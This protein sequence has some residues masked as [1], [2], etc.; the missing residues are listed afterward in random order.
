MTRG[1]EESTPIFMTRTFV[2]VLDRDVEQIPVRVVAELD[3]NQ[4]GETEVT[5]GS[6]V[7]LTDAARAQGEL[8]NA[9]HECLRCEA[10][11]RASL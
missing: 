3:K 7:R 1:P 10:M 11:E 8:I 9:E 6:V 5:I 2:S 4:Y